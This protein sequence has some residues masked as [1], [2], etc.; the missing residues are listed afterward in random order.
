MYYVAQVSNEKEEKTLA[1][2]P[3]TYTQEHLTF[4][5]REILTAEKLKWWKY[6]EKLK[7][8]ISINNKKEVRSLIGRIYI[9]VVKPR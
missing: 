5:N 3:S 8:V 6:L 1:K 7:F 4:N 9:H 2:L